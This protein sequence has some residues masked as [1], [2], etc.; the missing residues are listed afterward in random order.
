MSLEYISRVSWPPTPKDIMEPSHG[1]VLREKFRSVYVAKGVGCLI[2]DLLFNRSSLP[3]N[4]HNNC[5]S[6]KFESNV[7]CQ[8]L[9]KKVVQKHDM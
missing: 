8:F 1:R 5:G 7:Y 3:P 4:K 6:H 2:T 9:K